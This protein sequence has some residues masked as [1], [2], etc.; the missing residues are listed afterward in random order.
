MPLAVRSARTVSPSEKSSRI[1]VSPLTCFL[2]SLRRFISVAFSSFVMLAR[3]GCGVFVAVC[4]G[5]GGVTVG[6]R[7][8]TICLRGVIARRGTAVVISLTR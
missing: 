1:Q 7:L 3:L 5:A 6:D 4:C 2:S 8:G